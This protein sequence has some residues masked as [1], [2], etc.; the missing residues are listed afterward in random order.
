MEGRIGPGSFSPELRSGDPSRRGEPAAG[1]DIVGRAVGGAEQT[2]R[3]GPPPL[4]A[5]LARADEAPFVGRAEALGRLRDRWQ[6]HTRAAGGLVIVTGE[7]GIG[8]TRLAARLAADVHAEGGVVLCG[9][10]DEENVWPYQA[11]VEALRHYAAHRRDLVADARLPPTAAR[12]LAALMPEFGSPAAPERIEDERNRHQLF[13]AV[14]RLLL[15]AARPAGLL[16]V[17]EDLHWADAPTVL[18]LRHLLRRAEGSRLLVLATCRDEQPGKGGRLADLRRDAK[19]DTICLGGFGPAEAA[20]LVAVHAGDDAA[21]DTALVRRLCRVSGGNPFFIEELLSSPPPAPDQGLR[22]P[23][24]VKQVIGRRLDRLPR[25]SLEILTLAAVLGNEFDLMTLEVVASDRGQDE[26]IDAL[27]AAVAASLIV[28]DSE[29]VD[30]FAFA[31]ALVRETLY[32]RPIASRRLRLHRRV[33][34]ALE[35]SPLPVHPAELAHHYFQARAVGGA[36]KAIVYSLQAGVA[37]QQ[38]HAYEA[39]AEHYERVLAVLP[40]VG[41]ADAEARCDVLL[42]LGAARWQASDA[43]A[44]AAF[45]EA[46]ELARE[47]GSP[48]RLARAA[49][50]LGGRFYAPVGTDSAYAQLLREALDALGPGDSVVRV[51]VL[52]RLAE[53]LVFAAPADRALVLADEALDVA[54]RLAE[55]RP[56]VDALMGRHAALLHAEHAAERRRVGEEMLAVAGELEDAELGALARHWLLYDLAELGELA[57]ARQR[58]DELQRSAAELQQP[59]YRHSALAWRGVLTGLAGRFDDAERLA[60]RAVRLAERAGDPHA[61]MHFTAQLVAIRREQG[62]LNEL[63]PVIERFARGD[64]DAAAWRSILPLAY[65]DAGDRDRAREVYDQAFAD[66]TGTPRLLWLTATGSLCEAA[67]ELA[68]ADGAERLYHELSPCAD[69]L[70]PVD[71]HRKCRVRPAPARARRHA[72]GPARRR[73]PALRGG[74][75]TTFRAACAGLAGANAL[76]LRRTAH[77]GHRS[78]PAPGAS[79]FATP[80]RPRPVGSE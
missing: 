36:D 30:R 26:V 4:P 8:K 33:A 13:E 12:A 72:R 35:T 34:E 53:T 7:P 18:L 57:E 39:A 20:D 67:C 78:R 38:A 60:R 22:V 61:Q 47:F 49:L 1:A 54:Q 70:A 64:Y 58:C 31:H 11:F 5:A 37:A 71:L 73:A 40:L 15:H 56:L 27:E 10:A 23:T 14:V 59:L 69:R 80:P 24:A 63:L 74:A 79:N 19:F 66:R 55:P 16:L 9:R 51:R 45:A 17:L 32:E 28:E 65:L 29:Q 77:A 3:L 2:G 6:D 48:G 21:A 62:R 41:R 75:G 52:A 43:N 50:G 68:D 44:R 46:L 76:R 25:A 42:S